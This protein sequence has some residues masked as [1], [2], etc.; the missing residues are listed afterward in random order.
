MK[1]LR[2]NPLFSLSSNL[3]PQLNLGT[4]WLTTPLPKDDKTFKTALEADVFVFPVSFAQQ[5]LWFLEQLA[6]GNPF[7][8]VPTAVRLTGLLNLAAL[9]QTFNEI[10][11]RHEALRTT[12]RMLD[13]QPV[14]AIAPKLTLPL[15]VVDLQLSVIEREAAVERLTT[16]ELQQ[17]FD[18]A[19]GPLL[20]VQLL[21]LDSSE[22][23]LLLTLHHI[24][25]DGWS[26]GVLLRELGTLYTAFAT[27]QPSPLTE[28][29]IQYADFAHW[30]RQWLQGEVLATQLAYW[31]QQLDG[32]APSL[33]LP[34]DRPRPTR[35]TF[36][37]ARQS[38]ML[39]QELAK[40]IAALSERE[41]VT[42]FMTL[43]AAFQTLLYR[44]T[45]QEDISIGSPIANRNRSEIE[46]LIGFFVNSLV[47][48]T[49]LSGNPTFR[50]LLRRVREVALGAYAHQDL[51]FEKLVEELQPERDLSRNPLFQIV[52]A[53]QNTPSE[54]LE[55]PGLKLSPLDLEPGT[56]RF[57]LEFQLVEC[58]DT[59]GVVVTYSTDLFESSTIAQML[60]HFQALLNSIVT[61]S[62]QRITDLSL[63]TAQQHQLLEEWNDTQADYPKDLCFQQLFEAQVVQSPT[64][65]AI[66]FEDEQLT[67]R[68]LNSRSN[69]L[70]HYLQQLGVGPEVLVGICIERSCEM[71]VAIL[72]VL[73]AGGAYVPL[74]PVYPQDRL[75]YMLTDAHVSVLLTQSHQEFS[76][77]CEQDSL[78]VVYLDQNREAQQSKQNPTTNVTAANLA[79]VIYTSGS[80]GKPKGVLVQHQGLQNLAAAQIQ[81]LNLQQHNRILQFASL[82]FDASIFEVVMAL[83]VGATLYLAR[84]KS[85][86]ALI[87]LL[88]DRQITHVTLPPSVLAILP[89]DKFPA[90]QAVIAAGEACATELAQRWKTA[91]RRFFN[92]YGPTE[93]TV[94][95]TIDEFGDRCK[96]TLGRPIANTEVYLL[97]EQLQPVPIGARGELYIGGDGLARGYQNLP[98]LTAERF[99]PHPFSSQPGARLYQTGDLA[100]YR[101]DGTIEFLGRIDEQVKLRGLRIEL[102]EI[103]AVLI[104]HA[105][106]KQTSVIVQEDVPSSI[107]SNTL[108]N[109]PSNKRL[110]AYVVLHQDQ[111]LR[112]ENISPFTPYPQRGP[113]VPHLS[114]SQK[115]RYFLKERLPEYMVPST[116][117]ILEALPLTP[118]GK[119]NRRALPPP[120]G[121]HEDTY[122]DTYKE[123]I[124]PRNPTEVTLAEIWGQ[125]LN[126]KVGIHDDFF[127]L[128]GDSL[129]TMQLVDRIY[130]Q[131]G[132]ELPLSTLFLAPTIEQL[133]RHLQPDTE[134]L[135][136]PLI[137][138]QS[139]G[140]KPPFFCVHPILG[141]I[142]PYYELARHLG[143]DQPFYA[144][145]PLGIN[146]QT[147]HS[148]IEDMASCYI[149]ALRLVQPQG[150]YFLG[151]WSFG[152]LVAFEMAQQLQSKQQVAL[153]ALLDTPAPVATNKLSTRDSLQLFSTAAR[154]V[155]PY[156]LDYVQLI[157]ASKPTIRLMLRVLQASSQ[158]ALS[159]RPQVYSNRITLFRTSEQATKAHRFSTMGWNQLTIG[160]V[161]VHQVSGNHLTVLRQPHVQVLAKQISMCI[162]RAALGQIM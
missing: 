61:D 161:E 117:V 157:H 95:S 98:H 62:E 44:Y 160:E 114:I 128:G 23:I 18:L 126:L 146:G 42:L 6:P 21:Q 96:L 5:R 149:E 20:R 32:C 65:I 60:E 53:L 74:D 24:V 116:F 88:Q 25:A 77:R 73:K 100:R 64:A 31:Q 105:S 63:L 40:A 131:F 9:E 41:G 76:R 55:L 84:V 129:L 22:H 101:P 58:L 151:G 154:S 49:D 134:L 136:S 130:Q 59:L 152:G 140:S 33:A 69:Q 150:P 30:Q 16:K 36:R 87:R 97:D 37:G 71:I 91:G 3:P 27:G 110:I 81:V 92:A 109:I 123:Y 108:S 51:P 153:L 112:P 143:T 38:L 124:A 162:E 139:T 82:S 113:R 75:D 47:L 147:P 159:Y 56:A 156:V 78:V 148:R 13:G 83:Q 67:Y 12:F 115:L 103:E 48:R 11:R 54:T 2:H 142:F 104:Q 70:A 127:Q 93:A 66:V 122:E 107:R 29:P 132:R 89:P 137:A 144:L 86:S 34:T 120:D 158:A 155:W 135:W 46:G 125:L 8:N 7:Y 26:I 80:T 68:E 99:L 85:I 39:P 17:S 138:I 111:V 57:D 145:Q 90:L 4:R 19:Q 79:Y 35:P 106:V 50:E 94:W 45:G 118:G 133:A 14:Q 72:A 43:L 52:F 28:L 1:F 119:V 102:G 15:P 121:R 10:V 141:T